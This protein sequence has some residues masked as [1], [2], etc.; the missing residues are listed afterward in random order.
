MDVM[1]KWFLLRKWLF[2]H[3]SSA[4]WLEARPL[5]PLAY[6]IVVWCCPLLSWCQIPFSEPSSLHRLRLFVS[7]ERF[8]QT[9]ID[10][11]DVYLG[12]HVI[13]SCFPMKS[14]AI[15]T[16]SSAVGL[17]RRWSLKLK[18]P[19]WFVSHYCVRESYFRS[20]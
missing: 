2:V 3:V 16:G 6:F 19:T 14:R 9:N 12:K 7:L 15:S 18:L 4:G 5:S 13:G 10:D 8:L 17:L 1:L 20:A 11:G